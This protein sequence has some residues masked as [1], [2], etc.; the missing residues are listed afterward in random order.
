MDEELRIVTKWL[1]SAS[2]QITED[3]FRLSLAGVDPQYR[4]RVY[5]YELYHQWRRHWHDGVGYSLCGETD[6]RG[7]LYVHGRHV[8]NVKPDFLIHIPGRMTN[9]SNLLVMEVK[10]KT[11][12]PN[13]I[14]DDLEKLTAFRL[15]LKDEQGRSANYY[16]AFLWVYS[17]ERNKWPNLRHRLEQALT[18]KEVDLSLLRFF[19]H[20]RAAV[21]AVEVGWE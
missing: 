15:N 14:A 19:L 8:D 11:A 1:L 3:Y 5:C 16:A 18:K 20:E 10:P 2:S 9:D 4:E 6:K 13:E 21:S 17:L 12:D 7:H